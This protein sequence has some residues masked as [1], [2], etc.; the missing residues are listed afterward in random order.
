MAEANGKDS[1]VPISELTLGEAE[2]FLSS[3]MCT[4]E[5]T[6][7]EGIFYSSYL[8]SRSSDPFIFKGLKKMR[9]VFLIKQKTL[10]QALT[11][12]RRNFSSYK[13]SVSSTEH[14]IYGRNSL[15]KLFP[16]CKAISTRQWALWGLQEISCLSIAWI[17]TPRPLPVLSCPQPPVWPLS[18]SRMSPLRS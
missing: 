1:G 12:K 14:L 16:F 3:L 9:R 10:C 6:K 11:R 2:S 8:Y 15:L 5:K 13:V 17:Q 7:N 4:P 18:R